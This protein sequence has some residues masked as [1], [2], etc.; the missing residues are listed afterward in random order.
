LPK[1]LVKKVNSSWY[2]NAIDEKANI[3]HTPL[4]NIYSNG[5][6]CLIS[7]LDEKRPVIDTKEK[8]LER[9]YTS[10]FTFSECGSLSKYFQNIT[11]YNARKFYENWEN[12]GKI[13]LIPV[14]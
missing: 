5:Q 14:T 6:I 13:D 10:T 7:Y 3:F 9:F 8:F 12:T 11:Y 4:S 1:L 2:V